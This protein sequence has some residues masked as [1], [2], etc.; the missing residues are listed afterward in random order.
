MPADSV[1]NTDSTNHDDTESLACNQG[2]TRY[3]YC[4]DPVGTEV[5][6]TTI[7]FTIE[8]DI[9]PP[10]VGEASETGFAGEGWG[11]N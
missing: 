1:T 11:W 4:E 10:V 5:G 2:I 6:P 3:V 9:P 7:T 8:S